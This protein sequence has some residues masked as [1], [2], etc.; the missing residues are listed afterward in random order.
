[1]RIFDNIVDAFR[2]SAGQPS[3]I[4]PPV[5]ATRTTG[6]RV[7]QTVGP[8]G[9]LVSERGAI[10]V[11]ALDRPHTPLPDYTIVYAPP[12]DPQMRFRFTIV[13]CANGDFRAYIRQQPGYG[14][15]ATDAHS[16]HRLRDARG[17][18]VCWQPMPK[19]AADIL[20]VTRLW[21]DRTARYITTGTRLEAQ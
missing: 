16:T 20:R 4:V 10:R 8:D 7:F 17:H 14:S 12:S 21:A 11:Y 19:T 15:R 9:Q 3:G 1:V 6:A 13:R 5:A 2:S 18:F